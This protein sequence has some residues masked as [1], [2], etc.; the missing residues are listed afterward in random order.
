MTYYLK[1]GDIVEPRVASNAAEVASAKLRWLGVQVYQARDGTVMGQFVIDPGGFEPLEGV[2]IDRVQRFKVHGEDRI[3]FCPPS[4]LSRCPPVNFMDAQSHEDLETKV[5]A[6]WRA[7]AAQARQTLET[8]RSLAQNAHLLLEPWR[9]E[10]TAQVG[11]DEVR[12]LFSSGGDR[13]CVCGL[14]GR[15]LVVQPVTPRVIIPVF[16]E[17]PEHEQ[18]S[19]WRSA[20]EQARSCLSTQSPALPEENSLSLDLASQDLASSYGD[21]AHLA[22]EAQVM[23]HSQGVPAPPRMPPPRAPAAAPVPVAAPAYPPFASANADSLDLASLDLDS[24][25][26][27]L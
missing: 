25:D 26:L 19:L 14:N 22:Q 9:I 18:Q 20:I 24:M 21:V 10:G 12:V 16:N 15:A 7:V 23:A 17:D 2:R 11:R 3:S 5:A 27:P 8:A 4:A 6:A 13:A 1:G